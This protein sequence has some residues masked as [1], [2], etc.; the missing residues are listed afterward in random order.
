MGMGLALPLLLAAK[1]A[2]QNNFE[3]KITP[4]GYLQ[5]LL[6]N[7]KPN[8]I[9][10]SKDDGSGYLRDVKV[11]YKQRSTPDETA[12]EDDC[13]IQGKPAYNEVTIGSTLFRKISY[14]FDLDTIS[15]F[16]KDALALTNIGTPP[17]AIVMEV[18]D[19]IMSL[20]NGLI[21]AIDIDLL[22]L[23]A[24]NFGKNAVTGLNTARTVNF[25]LDG[26]ENN[27][28]EGMTMV[29]ADARF[30]ELQAASLAAVGSGLVDNYFLQL[31][32]N[33]INANQSGL[34]NSQLFRPAFYYDPYAAAAF[35]SNQFGLFE[36]NAVQIVN[37]ARFRGPKAGRFGQS[38]LGTVI[39]PLSDAFG[40]PIGA[41]ELDWQK[42]YIDCPSEIEIA[43]EIE[44]VGRGYSFDLMASF[45]QVNIPADAYKA[46]DRLTGVNGTLRYTAT[47][48]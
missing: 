25:N 1:R 24:A 13:S 30:N 41:L 45:T 47:N 32:A 9:S 19:S 35:G 14:Y 37:I 29:M 22:T 48:V 17:T 2:F 6:A 20:A 36:K 15:Q 26:T 34:N 10:T 38:E 4:P 23:Q 8:I 7:T 21:G 40:N 16:E 33:A 31:N 5:Y 39:L 28:N 27:L 3:T 11:R 46:S 18:M 44:T 43:G 12:T 42:K